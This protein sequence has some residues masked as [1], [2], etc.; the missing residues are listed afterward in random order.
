MRLYE[1]RVKEKYFE[2]SMPARP[3]RFSY[4]EALALCVTINRA[5]GYEM[6][7]ERIVLTSS[8][9]YFYIDFVDAGP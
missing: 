1:L 5:L 4:D 8:P 2:R 7:G 9:L 3:G 6:D